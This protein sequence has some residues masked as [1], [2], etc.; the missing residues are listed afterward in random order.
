MSLLLAGRE[1]RPGLFV[2][3]AI[4]LVILHVRLSTKSTSA[5]DKDHQKTKEE[6]QSYYGGDGN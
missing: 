6:G 5:R 1:S 3:C 2:A 4:S